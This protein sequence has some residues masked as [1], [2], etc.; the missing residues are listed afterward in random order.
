MLR[1]GQVRIPSGCAIS[2]FINKKGVRIS[3]TD[4]INSIAIMKERGN[5]LGGGFAAYGI[6]PDRKDWY[7]FHLFFDDIKAKEDTE[8]FLNQNFEVLESEV[9]PT[10]KVSSIQNAPI[11]WRYFVKPLEKKLRDTEKTEEDFVVDSVMFINSRIDGAYVFSSGKNM[12]AFKGVGY[13]EDIGEFFRIDEYK[14]YI[15]TAH[16]RFPTNTPGW[17]GGAHPFTLLDWSIVHNGEISSYGTNYRYLEMF[18]YKCTLRTDT[19][20]MAYLFDL[21]L[22]KHKLSVEIAAKALAAPFWSVIDRQDEKEREKLRAI[23]AVYSSCLV[24]GPFSIILGFSNGILA[25]NDRIK[26]RPLVAAQKGDF[27]YVASEEA[28]I[29]EICKDPEKVWMPKGGEPVYVTLDEG[30]IV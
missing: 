26:L 22:R 2:G 27:V 21:L 25:L 14:A 29:R 1:E 18:G 17:W 10:R 5:G 12:G 13:P 4:I 19:E 23:R 15:W 6:Y 8:H 16:S 11:V 28:A 24:N 3:G 30:V 20:V 7:A 9:I